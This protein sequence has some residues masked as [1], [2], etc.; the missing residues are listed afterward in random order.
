MKIRQKVNYRPKVV[1]IVNFIVGLIFN[2]FSIIFCFGSKYSDDDME[3]N[4]W[5][6]SILGTILSTIVGISVACFIKSIWLGLGILFALIII[7]IIIWFFIYQAFFGKK[8]Q[9]KAKLEAERQ[10]N[11]SELYYADKKLNNLIN[12]IVLKDEEILKRIRNEEFIKNTIFNIYKYFNPDTNEIIVK[13]FKTN[14]K[15]NA[16]IIT[17]PTIKQ[18]IDS[19]FKYKMIGFVDVGKNMRFFKVK[20]FKGIESTKKKD[21]GYF[22]SH[23]Y[24][25][26][27]NNIDEF[28]DFLKKYLE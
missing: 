11:S 17:L 2:F 28:K 10:K 1:F 8:S 23:T 21:D 20:N 27:I 6:G 19:S 13:Y 3:T 12:A 5:M 25:V 24:D 4:K 7:G 22:Y 14:S 18:V 9:E 16:I 15:N 26:A